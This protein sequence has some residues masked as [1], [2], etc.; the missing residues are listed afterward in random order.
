MPHDRQQERDRRDEERPHLDRGAAD[1]PETVGADAPKRQ[2]IRK[3]VRG[4]VEEHDE[5]RPDRERDRERRTDPADRRAARAVR[6]DREEVGARARGRGD[7]QTDDEREQEPR[8][9]DTRL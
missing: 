3:H 9:T 5:E 7:E 4:A 6:L 1:V 8:A 2:R